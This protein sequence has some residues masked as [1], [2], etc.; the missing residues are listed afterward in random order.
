MRALRGFADDAPADEHAKT[1]RLSAKSIRAL[2]GH[3]RARFL[4]AMVSDPLA[5][6]GLGFF[7]VPDGE[8]SERGTLLLTEIIEHPAFER[9]LQ[10]HNP[11]AKTPEQRRPHLFEVAVRLFST[12]ALEKSPEGLYP[13]ETRAAIAD[14]MSIMRWVSE[15][16]DDPGFVDQYQDFLIRLAKVSEAL[17]Q[18]ISQEEMR[19]FITQSTEHRFANDVIYNDLRR[20]LRKNPISTS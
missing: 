14:Y 19:A 12:L 11:R 4:P 9:H 1:I 10:R 8:L 17:P 3:F 6:G 18:L 16:R 2:Y 7:L 15:H 20:Y 5:F 13:D